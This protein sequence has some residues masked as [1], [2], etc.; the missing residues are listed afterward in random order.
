[1]GTKQNRVPVVIF[2]SGSILRVE[3]MHPGLS[4][5]ASLANVPRTKHCDR[6]SPVLPIPYFRRRVNVEVDCVYHIRAPGLSGLPSM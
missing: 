1:M 4:V 2:V 5:G 3:G 6:T